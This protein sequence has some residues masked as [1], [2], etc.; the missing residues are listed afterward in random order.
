MDYAWLKAIRDWLLS[1]PWPTWGEFS[2]LIKAFSSLLWPVVVLVL[3]LA[4]KNDLRA[5]LAN[6]KLK[7]GK[8]F[9]QEFELEEELN[10]LDQ[11]TK[12]LA[13]TP[14]PP[15]EEEGPPTPALPGGGPPPQPEPPS[16][17]RQ[18]LA[19]AGSSPKAALMLLASEI[20]AELR[21]VLESRSADPGPRSTFR[22]SV[23]FLE[24]QEDFPQELLGL[25]LK[26]RDVRN[27]IIHGYEADPDDVLRAIDVGLRILSAIRRLRGVP[28]EREPV[29]ERPTSP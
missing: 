20:E 28:P 11:A 6:R 27:R 8:L 7:R 9:G 5:L 25:M 14:P 15:P 2:E 17:A 29:E 4:F 21:R 19:E 24:Q 3:I 1:L 12:Q 23:R 13:E 22:D 18:I 26:F 16:V 10:R